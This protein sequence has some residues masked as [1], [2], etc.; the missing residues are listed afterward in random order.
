MMKDIFK[1]SNDQLLSFVC[2]MDNKSLYNSIY[3]T[4]TTTDKPLLI[5][6][7]EVLVWIY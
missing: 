3:S 6:K 1:I 2:F 4:K 5:D 7:I